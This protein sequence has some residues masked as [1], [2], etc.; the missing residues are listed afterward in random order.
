MIEQLESGTIAV[1]TDTPLG[2]ELAV[3]ALIG[4][5]T[6]TL[7]DAEDLNEEGG[8]LSIGG[9][10]IAYVAAD[11]DSN[12][13]T[14]AT[15]TTIAHVTEDELT[16][17]PASV[18]RE[19]QVVLDTDGESVTA[20]VPH[21]LW[22]R[23]GEGI[24]DSDTAERV[25]LALDDGAWSLQDVLGQEPVID[26]AYIDE[27]TLPPPVIPPPTDLNPPTQAATLVFIGGIG[28]IFFRWD[29]IDNP[30]PVTYRL[31]VNAGSAPALDGSMQ[32][33]SGVGLTSA[34]VRK[35][36][37]G[38]GIVGDGSVTYY[39]I[40]TVEDDDGPGP[41]SNVASGVPA[42]VT[43][44]DIFV[45]AITADMLVANDAL[46]DALQAQTIT[47]VTIQGSLF[48]TAESPVRRIE[49]SD[50]VDGPL[51]L[52][53]GLAGETIPAGLLWDTDWRGIAGAVLRARN[54]TA[55]L[56]VR[57]SSTALGIPAAVVAEPRL[58]VGGPLEAEQPYVRCFMTE[59]GNTTAHNVAKPLNLTGSAWFFSDDGS[60]LIAYD[61]SGGVPS[62]RIAEPGWYHCSMRIQWTSNTAGNRQ[63]RI[64]R[65]TK[66]NVSLNVW[67]WLLEEVDSR[68]P[69]SGGMSTSLSALVRTTYYDERLQFAALQTSGINLALDGGAPSAPGAPPQMTGTHVVV[70]KL[71]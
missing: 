71:P 33:A 64:Y 16:V 53:S 27:T 9:E 42:Q 58:D 68:P 31:H 10:V 36:R 13:V 65:Y 38:T 12:V 55:R 17:L 22:D 23:I 19:A 5:T 29:E 7:V 63:A 30:D 62:L 39:G 51:R 37:D 69:H 59:S 67:D 44:P 21:A 50:H 34:A 43:T 2:G 11:L 14:L 52:Y 61:G 57:E 24:R 8:Q 70:R 46:F 56:S 18:E 4:S 15:P 54:D 35:L 26:G 41:S 20:R 6:L 28:S 3:D 49:I 47:G 45:G 60:G 25:T 48:R 66:I 40:V 1:V 32:V